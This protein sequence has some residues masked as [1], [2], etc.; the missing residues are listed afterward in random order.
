LMSDPF[1]RAWATSRGPP[2]TAAIRPNQ[3]VPRRQIREASAVREAE[4]R[5]VGIRAVE[6]R[7]G[8]TRETAI[9]ATANRLATRDPIPGAATEI[10]TGPAL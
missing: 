10:L 7:G 5:A 2:L 8:A 9:P 1:T 3:P 4:T 6:I